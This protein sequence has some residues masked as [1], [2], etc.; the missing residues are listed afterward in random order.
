MS[1][2]SMTAFGSGVSLSEDISATAEI[3]TLNSRFIEVNVR[4]P[5]G[6]Q[7][8]EIALIKLVRAGLKRG[9]S[10]HHR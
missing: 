6:F 1:I 2:T 10:G 8:L 7:D 3:K 5:R 9:K 4:L